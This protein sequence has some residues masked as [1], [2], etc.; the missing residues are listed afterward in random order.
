MGSDL[1]GTPITFGPKGC[2]DARLT[3]QRSWEP[4]GFN[5]AYMSRPENLTPDNIAIEIKAI[6]Q[7]DLY[8]ISP[9]MSDLVGL[10]LPSLP[11][12]STLAVEMIPAPM[13]LAFFA[14]PIP[15]T[16]LDKPASISALHWDLCKGFIDIGVFSNHP[17]FG[18]VSCGGN[19][20]RLNTRLDDIEAVD[21]S[22]EWPTSTF[23]ERRFALAFFALLA[24]P[25]IATTALERADRSARKRSARA[26]VDLSETRVVYLRSPPRSAETSSEESDRYHHRWIVDG[27]WRSQP[28]GPASALRKP[29]WIGAHVK[30]PEGAPLLD[31][32]KVRAVVR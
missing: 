16:T 24:S 26:G 4:G 22:E 21:P 2:P 31:G 11:E 20:W 8:W 3:I 15:P 14:A 25:G 23:N 7:S 13:G 27:H 1:E 6:R 17:T 5:L 28:Y 32:T 30:G 12:D 18:F 19:H 9:E 29:V 10:A